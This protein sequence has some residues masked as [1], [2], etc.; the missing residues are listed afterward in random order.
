[1]KVIIAGSRSIDSYDVVKKAV[2]ASG[3]DVTEVVSGGSYGVDKLG[4]RWAREND[5]PVKQFIPNWMA[6]GASAGPIRNGQMAAYADALIAVW[7]GAS[8]GT[9]N[10]M[11]QAEKAR[12]KIY[13]VIVRDDVEEKE[14]KHGAS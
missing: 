1:M 2:E 4:E 14:G 6:Y 12:L 13:T 11:K 9:A 8:R 3:I 10:M 7:D 5:V